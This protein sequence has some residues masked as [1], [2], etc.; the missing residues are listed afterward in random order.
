MRIR[1]YARGT[2]ALCP[3]QSCEPDPRT[4]K[5]RAQMLARALRKLGYE[6]AITPRAAEAFTSELNIPRCLRMHRICLPPAQAIGGVGTY[7]PLDSQ[8]CSSVMAI[9]RHVWLALWP[10]AITAYQDMTH[11]IDKTPGSSTMLTWRFS[12]EQFPAW[13]AAAP[14]EAKGQNFRET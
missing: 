7:T 4:K 13:D 10:L 14:L 5:K 1:R 11:L 2:N 6:V 3:E 12:E 9:L 8:P